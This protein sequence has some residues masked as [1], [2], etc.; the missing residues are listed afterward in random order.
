MDSVIKIR[1][2]SHLLWGVAFSALGVIELMRKVMIIRGIP[3][4]TISFFLVG[5]GHFM[6]V[7][8]LWRIL[9]RADDNGGRLSRIANILIAMGVLILIVSLVI[10][11]ASG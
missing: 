11:F 5:I 7:P 9:G 6:K 10:L 4:W 2:K 1:G 3:L 8:A